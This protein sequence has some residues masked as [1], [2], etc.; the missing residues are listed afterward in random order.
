MSFFSWFRVTFDGA[1]V[2][3]LLAVAPGARGSPLFSETMSKNTEPA[4]LIATDHIDGCDAALYERLATLLADTDTLAAV[5]AVLTG[6]F[7]TSLRQLDWLVT[8]FAKRVALRITSID[9]RSVY[10][11]DEYK[12]CLAVYRRRSFD[13][14]CR[15]ARRRSDGTYADYGATLHID[16]ETSARSTLAQLNFLCWAHINGVLRYA[17]RAR[18][19]IESDMLRTTRA[20]KANRHVGIGKRSR[21]TTAPVGGCQVYRG[22]R[23]VRL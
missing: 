3:H 5:A 23:R 17:S 15:S 11:H 1:P 19:T 20:S 8:N 16:A 6:Q 10:V 13:P 9:G 18:A 7:D 14:F 22:I 2:G 21:L 12:A 4:V